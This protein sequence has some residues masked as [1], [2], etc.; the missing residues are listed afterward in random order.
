MARAS[1]A[2]ERDSHLFQSREA[3][4]PGGAP[5]SDPRRATG[6]GDS[7]LSN[8]GRRGLAAMSERGHRQ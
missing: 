3:D 5:S 4:A 7:L 8:P 1:R 2:N 6:R